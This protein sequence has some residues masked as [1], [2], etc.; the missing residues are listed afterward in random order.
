[1]A[2]KFAK[3]PPEWPAFPRRQNRAL[4]V[5]QDAEIKSIIDGGKV[6]VKRREGL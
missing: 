1:M 2:G 5:M 6:A 4:T 3:I